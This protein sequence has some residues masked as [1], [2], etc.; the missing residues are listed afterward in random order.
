MNHLNARQLLQGRLLQPYHFENNL[1]L[2]LRND[3]DDQMMITIIQLT[4]VEPGTTLD[5]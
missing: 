5:S 2:A 1:M 3:D 4:F